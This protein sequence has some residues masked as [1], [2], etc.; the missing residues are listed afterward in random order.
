M[1][2]VNKGLQWSKSEPLH[3][4][5]FSFTDD[6]PSILLKGTVP[7]PSHPLTVKVLYPDNMSLKTALLTIDKARLNPTMLD[8]VEIRD[9][10]RSQ[11]SRYENIY[12]APSVLRHYKTY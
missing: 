10:S 12:R 7:K 9:I 6:T 8:S 1:N 11:S 2:A 5:K 3:Q 4:T